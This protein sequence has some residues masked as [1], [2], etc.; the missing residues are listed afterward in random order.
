MKEPPQVLFTIAGL[1]PESGGPARSVPALCDALA[2]RG[3]RPEIVALSYGGRT[4]PAL[5]AS[6][7]EVVTTL[8]PCHSWWAHR[9]QWSGQ[10]ATMLE[11]RCRV[12]NA[13]IIHDTGVWLSTNHA[14]AALAKRM[15]LKRVVS[16]RGMLTPWALRHKALKKRIAWRLYQ[17]RDLRRA[18]LLHA[19]SAAE[20]DDLRACGLTQ[21][22]A[23]IPNGVDLPAAADPV[24]PSDPA[25]T[26]T[27]L[28][29]SRI[30]PKKGLLDLV[31]AWAQV[32]PAGWQLVLAGPDDQGHR[33]EVEAAI[34]RQ[35][36]M[37]SITFVGE[38]DDAAKWDWYRKADLFVLPSHSENFGIAV[39]EALA[40][41]VPVITTQGTPWQE[42][43]THR[44]GWWVS[45][46]TPGLA[47]ALREAIQCGA[48]TRG[49]MG[50]RGRE[51]VAARYS[52]ARAAEQ[53]GAA[54][55]WLL[56][57]GPRPE[58]VGLGSGEAGCN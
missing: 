53:M 13:A 21:P 38:L 19:T 37:D 54:Y 51:L 39:A 44:C 15:Q 42:L 35:G 50:R 33:A 3:W 16:P 46:G 48:A 49:E 1:H 30:H 9:L 32:R 2:R 56:G 12:T 43:V 10:F 22:V 31:S 25:R 47:A 41:G 24:V 45:I 17:E 7:P 6:R 34:D 27:L 26:H 52:W 58:C 5:R 40:C 28:F 4:R 36:V 29:L 55:A 11:R 18:H 57:A 20:R 8:V 23:V 14:A